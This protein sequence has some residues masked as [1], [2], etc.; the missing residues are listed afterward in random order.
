MDIESTAV[1]VSQESPLELTV[2]FGVFAGRSASRDDIER[3]WN[4]LQTH[5]SGV[6]VFAGRRYEFA[7]E[8]AEV[9]AYEDRSR[10]GDRPLRDSPR[11]CRASP[12]GGGAVSQGQSLGHVP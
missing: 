6:T 9:A 11:T 2:N 10:V 8:T 1:Y 12:W 5:V 7:H 3:L 4:L